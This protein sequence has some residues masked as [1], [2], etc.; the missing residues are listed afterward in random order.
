MAHMER[1]ESI[2]LCLDLHAAFL[3]LVVGLSCMAWSA[4]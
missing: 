3:G 1:D 2:G 4:S